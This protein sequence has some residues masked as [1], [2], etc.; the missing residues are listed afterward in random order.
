METIIGVSAV[1]TEQLLI[2]IQRK[3][4]TSEH[5]Y[6]KE[7]VKGC[8]MLCYAMWFAMWKRHLKKIV[9]HCV[10]VFS[11]QNVIKESIKK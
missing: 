8:A 1:P 10:G 2:S 11:K 7:C 9:V 6:N 4:S 5:H 3:V